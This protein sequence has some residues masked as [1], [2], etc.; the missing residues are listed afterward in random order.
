MKQANPII[1]FATNPDLANSRFAELRREYGNTMTRMCDIYGMGL[2]MTN[3]ELRMPVG[4][5]FGDLELEDL[6]TLLTTGDYFME[7]GDP[8]P[9]DRTIGVHH[10]KTG[11]HIFVH[12]RKDG[13]AFVM[14]HTNHRD[15][16]AEDFVIQVCG[17][18]SQSVKPIG[19]YDWSYSL[20]AKSQDDVGNLID[21][22]QLSKFERADYQLEV[23]CQHPDT[24]VRPVIAAKVL[25]DFDR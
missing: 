24:P 1:V 7:S 4:S 20:S 11:K 17:R 5:V 2:L 22:L 18:H 21:L 15:A 14:Y 3:F 25:N 12:L 10:Q 23:P 8:V 9:L 6:L 16:E 19:E 13:E